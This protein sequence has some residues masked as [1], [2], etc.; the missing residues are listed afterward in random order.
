[1]VFKSLTKLFK[2]I[3]LGANLEESIAS[4]PSA[5]FHRGTLRL[6]PP[7]QN[8]FPPCLFKYNKNLKSKANNIQWPQNVQEL[9][10]ST[11]W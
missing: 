2:K 3:Q 7:N 6:V 1:L 10:D 11:K 8:S 5:N 4:W 9:S